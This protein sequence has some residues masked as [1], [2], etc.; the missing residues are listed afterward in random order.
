MAFYTKYKNVDYKIN[1]NQA[2]SIYSP[3]DA[4]GRDC[5]TTQAA[6]S[7]RVATNYYANG[8][9]IYAKI[10]SQYTLTISLTNGSYLSA[11]SVSRNT[12]PEEQAATGSLASGTTSGGTAT[13][14]LNDTLSSSATKKTDD[15]SSWSITSVSQPQVTATTS[16]SITVKNTN[17]FSVTCYYGTT[18]DPTTSAG[19]VSGNNGTLTI[20]GLSV[21]TN[22]WVKFTASRTRTKHTYSTPTLSWSTATVSGATTLTITGGCTDTT[23][24]GSISSSVVTTSTGATYT[25]QSYARTGGSVYWSTSQITTSGGTGTLSGVIMG[26]TIYWRIAA[27]A[28][29]NLPSTYYGSTTLNST[30]FSF[31]GENASYIGGEISNCTR[32]SFTISTAKGGKNYGSW[33]SSSMTA[34]YGDWIQRSGNVVTIYKWDAPTTARGTLT[35]IPPDTSDVPSAAYYITY[36]NAPT[37]KTQ[38]NNNVAYTIT[39]TTTIN[40]YD[41]F[42]ITS[43]SSYIS[44]S[45]VTRTGSA[46]QGAATGDLSNG[47]PIY[48]GDSLK[49][50]GTATAAY[51]VPASLSAP[52][53]TNKTTT[54]LTVNNSNTYQVTCYYGTSSG[55]TTNSVTVPAKSGSTNGTASITGLSPSRKYYFFFRYAGTKYTQSVAITQNDTSI[56]SGSFIIVDGSQTIRFTG[57]Q[58]TASQN[59]NS[60]NANTT[61]N[62]TTYTL[63]L[64]LSGTYASS[65]QGTV[66]LRT[67]STTGTVVKT[68]T[69]SSGTTSGTQIG[70]YT[71]TTGTSYY[72]TGTSYTSGSYTYTISGTHGPY[73]S[74]TTTSTNFVVT[75]SGGTGCP[76]EFCVKSEGLNLQ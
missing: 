69:V 25:I 65:Y 17:S 61:M 68:I 38:I 53:F 54:S 64:K 37:T 5:S 62:S 42:I 27:N 57:S 51:T 72:L 33:S 59:V 35:F 39:A 67:G 34:Y 76:N 43:G 6:A 45:T 29:Y 16:T 74:S 11:W 63:N 21:G 47:D 23:E 26:Q 73:Y 18:S 60:S 3:A 20:S 12:S 40:V 9:Q 48:Y 49:V 50:V 66:Y 22:Y 41:L 28:G 1:P 32:Q 75:R 8:S 55:S 24:S 30:N 13:V 71:A 36:T 15:Y 4:S 52:T 2:S 19:T 44:T 7:T 70:T 31:S 14:Y 56:T 10:A 46:Y 58:S